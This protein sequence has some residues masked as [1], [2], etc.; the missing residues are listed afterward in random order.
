MKRIIVVFVMFISGLTTLFAQSSATDQGSHAVDPRVRAAV[1]QVLDEYMATFNAK[2]LAGWERTYQFPHYRLASGK[3][4]VLEKA[5]LRDSAK[6][7]GELKKTG[8]DHSQWDHRN[9]IQA[10]ADKVHVDTEFSRYRAD[11]SLIG[12]FESLYILTK[13]DGKWGIKF[14]SSY[15]E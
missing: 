4:S 15:A 6:V 11:G 8:W 3:M 7:F 13:E 5:G 10:S 1:F 9:I 2:D 14:R 12:H